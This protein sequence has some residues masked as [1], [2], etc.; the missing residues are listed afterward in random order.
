MQKA[1][2]IV[3]L[4][5]FLTGCAELGDTLIPPHPN[6]DIRDSELT[7]LVLDPVPSSREEMGEELMLKGASFVIGWAI[8]QT[9]KILEK[10][11]GRYTAT[12]S[13]RNS[14]DLYEVSSDRSSAKKKLGGFTLTRFSGPDV[15]LGCGKIQASEKVFE[16]KAQIEV[17]T[18]GNAVQVIPTQ[19]Y[20]AKTKAKVPALTWWPHT[21]WRA[22]DRNSGK[23]ELSATIVMT[24][25]RESTESV[26]QEAVMK[27]DIPLGRY[28][29]TMTP[30]NANLAGT[31]SGWF[32]LPHIKDAKTQLITTGLPTTVTV[33]ITE[34]EKLGDVLGKASK[35]M[36]NNKQKF[37]DEI[38]KLIGL[39][40]SH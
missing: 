31:A 24:T 22:L 35:E 12:Y 6:S 1:T 4:I 16:L 17:N 11:A 10:E 30:I 13:A 36:I 40:A 32:P 7:C 25:I 8:D 15:G 26:T 39:N 21:W 9:A 33:T 37:T 23:V 20:L 18:D 29:L 27:V 5:I 19:M 2:V 38:L 14:G 3:S 28:K 34:S